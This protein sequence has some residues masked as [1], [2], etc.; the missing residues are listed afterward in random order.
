MKTTMRIL[1]L[2][3]VLIGLHSTFGYAQWDWCHLDLEDTWS[4]Y[5]YASQ[6]DLAVA[7]WKVFQDTVTVDE[8]KTAFMANH[9]KHGVV[10][11]YMELDSIETAGDKSLVLKLWQEGARPQDFRNHKNRKHPFTGAT[12]LLH[13]P[14]HYMGFTVSPYPTYEAFQ[15]GKL[16]A[17]SGTSYGGGS[18][19]F[20]YAQ[21]S[22][23][24]HDG[25]WSDSIASGAKLMGTILHLEKATE[26]DW[27]ECSFSVLVY[28][29]A[30]KDGRRHPK[31]EAELLLPEKPDSHVSIYLQSFKWF[32]KDLP[33]KTF[34]PYYT[35]DG[36]ILLGRYYRVTVNKCGWLVEDYLIINH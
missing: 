1:L 8:M 9:D 24:T 29:K 26:P 3:L 30:D 36:R 19:F 12:L 32:V 18:D 13:N 14:E 15:K 10:L 6:T 25:L 28:E 11:P 23:K 5:K 16:I 22:M 4:E 34:K 21:Q 20:S 17:H 35:S 31:Y 2:S 7:E 27:P 33:Y